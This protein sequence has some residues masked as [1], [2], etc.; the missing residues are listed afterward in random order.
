VLKR[1]LYADAGVPS[2]LVVD[3][4][5]DV[6]VAVQYALSGVDY[7]EVTRSR[8]GVLQLDRPFAATVDLTGI[9]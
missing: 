4:D 3:A 5:A 6:P 2:Y 9:P 1:Q 8:D 7:H